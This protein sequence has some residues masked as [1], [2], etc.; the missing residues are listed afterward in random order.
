MCSISAFRPI[1][2]KS[3]KPISILISVFAFAVAGAACGGSE[4]DDEPEENDAG[5]VIVTDG[6]STNDASL[7]D[8]Q[9]EDDASIIA[10]DA[11]IPE[12][13]AGILDDDASISDD[14][15][16][17][18]FPEDA[19]IDECDPG[20]FG[21]NCALCTC[22][23]GTCDDGKDGEGKCISCNSDIWTGDNC[24]ACKN[25]LM[26]GDN[27]DQCKNGGSGENCI[28][29]SS[30]TDQDNNTYKTVIIDGKEWMAENYRRKTGTYYYPNNKEDNLA[31]Y[32]L[33][34]DWNTATKSGFCPTGWHL[35]TTS[36]FNDLLDYAGSDKA[37]RSQNLRAASWRK[38]ADKYGFS[39]LPAGDYSSGNYRFFG[40]A[41]F[42]WSDTAKSAD[43]AFYLEV[44]DSSS[45]VNNSY[46]ALGNSVRCLKDAA[47]TK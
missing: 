35:P 6:G 15:A 32:G 40:E 12:D 25:E 41:A 30:V 8:A 21:S 10:D 31:A 9:P 46:K 34:Y 20:Y 38:G 42:F 39:A 45:Q 17:I 22:K 26:T 28:L 5:I 1:H 27:C 16:S 2:S 37:T 36:E 47:V 7:S 3:F 43:Y 44:G 18:I 13:D 29:Y 23:H 14:D 19:G 33:L 11:S 4:K 24:D